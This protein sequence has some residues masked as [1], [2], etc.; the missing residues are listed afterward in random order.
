MHDKEGDLTEAIQSPD[1][2]RDYLF[3]VGFRES[4]GEAPPLFCYFCHGDGDGK[5]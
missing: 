2:Y 3:R 4:L 1:F 5:L